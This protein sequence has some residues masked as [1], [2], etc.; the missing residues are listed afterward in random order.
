MLDHFGD[1]A[2]SVAG[3]RARN[4]LGPSDEEAFVLWHRVGTAVRELQRLRNSP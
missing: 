2:A 1:A 3:E 4:N